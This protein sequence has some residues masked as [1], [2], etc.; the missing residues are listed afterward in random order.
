NTLPAGSA[1]SRQRTSHHTSAFTL[2]HLPASFVWSNGAR[3]SGSTGISTLPSGFATEAI[4]NTKST[5]GRS[6]GN[7]SVGGS[8]RTHP[9]WPSSAE[10][11]THLQSSAWPTWLSATKSVSRHGSTLCP[12]STIQNPIGTSGHSLQESK[13]G[14]DKPA[15]TST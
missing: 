3:R 7:R 5:S 6:S 10:E 9:F 2:F 11:W 15:G 1:N 13:S 4:S 8:D 12:I 14:A